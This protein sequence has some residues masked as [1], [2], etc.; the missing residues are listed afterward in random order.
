MIFVD[1]FFDESGTD[2]ASTHAVVAGFVQW[3]ES[4]VS[5]SIDW[6]RVLEAPPPIEYFHSVEANHRKGQFKGW[7]KEDRDAKVI[8]LIDVLKDFRAQPLISVAKSRDYERLLREYPEC[9]PEDPYIFCLYNIFIDAVHFAQQIEHRLRDHVTISLHFEQNDEMEGK[10]KLAYRMARN[11]DPRMVELLAPSISY[12]AKRK[13]RPLQAADALAYDCSRY[14]AAL[15]ADPTANMRP[16]LQAL[17]SRVPLKG[18]HWVWDY[19]KLKGLF[20]RK[21]E[22]L[23]ETEHEKEKKR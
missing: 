9:M 5:F 22:E 23:L 15:D 18:F 8:A 13:Y 1:G 7:E 14:F 21:Y 11:D 20:C 3:S 17:L 2:A 10:A 19:D 6:G 4:W 12:L 16:S